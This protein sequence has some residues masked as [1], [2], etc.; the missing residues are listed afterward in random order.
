MLTSWLLAG[1]LFLRR[2]GVV[3]GKRL[4]LALSRWT[5]DAFPALLARPRS[6]ISLGS[7]LPVPDAFQVLSAPPC[8]SIFS[9]LV[10]PSTVPVLV[11]CAVPL[12]FLFQLE[13]PF[14]GIEFA[15]L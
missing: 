5:S 2:P 14:Y 11:L 9:G 3:N 12:V 15:F 10:F 7:V 8:L 13:F 4:R 1:P 6:S